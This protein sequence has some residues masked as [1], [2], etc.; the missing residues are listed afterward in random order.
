MVHEWLRGSGSGQV[1]DERVWNSSK[2]WLIVRAEGE[3]CAVA[4]RL[5]QM[6]HRGPSQPLTF[7][8]SVKSNGGFLDL[9]PF[10]LLVVTSA[11]YYL[12]YRS[13]CLNFN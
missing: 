10:P 3:R 4:S 6:T 8:D 1:E 11:G 7:C 9:M 5:D 2:G 13:W 12:K